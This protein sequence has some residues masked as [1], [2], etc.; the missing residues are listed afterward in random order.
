MLIHPDFTNTFDTSLTKS[1]VSN[2]YLRFYDTF[3][4]GTR[5]MNWQHL[6]IISLNQLHLWNQIIRNVSQYSSDTTRW[7]NK[8][9]APSNF[10]ASTTTRSTGDPQL[11]R[12][13][14]R[15]RCC[16]RTDTRHTPGQKKLPFAAPL[17]QGQFCPGNRS[18]VNIGGKIVLNKN[19]MRMRLPRCQL[20]SPI[21]IF[22]IGDAEL[23]TRIAEPLRHEE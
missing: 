2:H 13:V 21:P 19:T 8:S 23:P 4:S 9:K 22:G 16:E 17:F 20:R 5:P 11:S 12:K 6:Q 14:I 15:A 10:P 18:S 1:E 3:E 7:E